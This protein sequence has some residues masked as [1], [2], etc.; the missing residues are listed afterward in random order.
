MRGNHWS[1][2]SCTTHTG[3]QAPNLWALGINSTVTSCFIGRRSTPWLSHAPGLCEQLVGFFFY[4]KLGTH[5]HNVTNRSNFFSKLQVLRMRLVNIISQQSF[6]PWQWI[7]N[8]NPID[9]EGGRERGKTTESSR[10]Q[11]NLCEQTH[12]AWLFSSFPR[13]PHLAQ[14]DTRQWRGLPGTCGQ[15]AVLLLECTAFGGV[16]RSPASGRLLWPRWLGLVL[17][18]LSWFKVWDDPQSPWP[19]LQPKGKEPAF[20]AV[21]EKLRMVVSSWWPYDCPLNQAELPIFA[22]MDPM[23]PRVM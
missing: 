9:G 11:R 3:D 4:T 21:G 18:G 17:A 20:T 15:A 10:R 1:A 16:P 6:L 5:G 8:L 7:L 14:L 12:K 2:A 22:K 19:G 23:E 13:K